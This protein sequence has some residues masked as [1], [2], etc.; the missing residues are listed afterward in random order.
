M[1]QR[2]L[3]S[4][5]VSSYNNEQ[6]VIE[7][8]E[9]INAQSYNDIEIIIVDDKS[10][11]NSVAVIEEW[12]K[13]RCRYSSQIIK[14]TINCGI[15]KTLNDGIK[16]VNGKYIA[17]CSSDDV[18][19]QDKIATQVEILEKSGDNIAMLYSDA[20]LIDENSAPIYGWFIQRQR[21]DFITPPSGNIFNNLLKGNFIP[22]NATLIKKIVFESI[23]LFDEALEYEDYDMWLRIAE[24]YP[25]IY[26]QQ[27]S[28]LYRIK[29]S[30]FSFNIKSWI[31]PNVKIFYKYRNQVEAKPVLRFFLVCAY[32]KK[33]KSVYDFIKS[34]DNKNTILAIYY[35]LFKLKVPPFIAVRILNKI[36]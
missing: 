36:S 21:Q 30:S 1:Q 19:L 12:L 6:Y 27:P 11:D 33:E 28:L 15:C 4:V 20:Y 31:T 34:L 25:I 26:S 17:I 24:K 7:T 8:L 22:A 29:K 10:T 2:P 3:V 16:S 14:H 32:T 13:T 23:G 18:M 35:Y 9:S 5:I